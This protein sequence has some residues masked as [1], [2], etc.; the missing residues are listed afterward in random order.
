LVKDYYDVDQTSDSM[1][2]QSMLSIAQRCA[3]GEVGGRQKPKEGEF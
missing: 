2:V 3:M 1:G